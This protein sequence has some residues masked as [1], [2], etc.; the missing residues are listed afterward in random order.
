M[1]NGVAMRASF[2]VLHMP[3]ITLQTFFYRLIEI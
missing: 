2:P 1:L 3:I